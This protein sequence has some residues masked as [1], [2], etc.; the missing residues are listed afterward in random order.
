MSIYGVGVN[1]WPKKIGKCALCSAKCVI[2]Q[3]ELELPK[4]V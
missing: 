3:G 4:R 2:D 1:W